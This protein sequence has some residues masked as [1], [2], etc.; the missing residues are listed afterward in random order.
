M[1]KRMQVLAVAVLVLGLAA[2]QKNTRPD[3]T[4]AP[5]ADTS[6]ASSAGLGVEVAAGPGTSTATPVLTPQQQ[7]LAELKNKNVVYFEFDSSE[8][9]PQ[10]VQV[11][12]A[13]AAYLVKYPTARVR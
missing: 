8:I 10:Y 3:E 11:V 7:A 1:M 4:E 12:A 9:G 6:A 13:H 2:C 5:P